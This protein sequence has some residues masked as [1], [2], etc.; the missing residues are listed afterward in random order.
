MVKGDGCLLFLYLLSELCSNSFSKLNALVLIC[1][2]HPNALE[3]TSFGKPNS[4]VFRNAETVLK[5]LLSSL[6]HKL[7]V[8]HAI[9]ESH[10]KT[11]Y[12]VGDNP[13]VDIKGARQVC[14]L[15]SFFHAL[16]IPRFIIYI[17]CLKIP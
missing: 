12:M 6:D 11:V 8:D 3:Y 13:T 4:F 1:R 2:I 17:R 5:Q 15:I 14:L 7:H 10:F 9:D 16:G